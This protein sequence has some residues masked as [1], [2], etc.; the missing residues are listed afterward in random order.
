VVRYLLRQNNLKPDADVRFAAVGP[1]S[2][3]VNALKNGQV[4]MIVGGIPDTEQPELEG[5]G[6][7][8][9]RLGNEIE[10]SKITHT[11]PCTRWII[12]SKPIPT[13]RVLCCGRL[14]A[15]TI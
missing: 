11:N 10:S 9:I 12:I 1:G 3:R 2:A 8:F 5:W 6:Y 15:A 7:T 14:R 13:R 4:D